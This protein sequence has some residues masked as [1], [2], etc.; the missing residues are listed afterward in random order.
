MGRMGTG[1]KEA[2]RMIVGCAGEEEAEKGRGLSQGTRLKYGCSMTQVGR[3]RRTASDIFVDLCEEDKTE[4]GD[5][6]D[7]GN[8]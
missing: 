7:A 6:I 2:G 8:S 1:G 3:A 5:N 4:P